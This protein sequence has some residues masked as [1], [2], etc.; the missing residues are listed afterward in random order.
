MLLQY[1]NNNQL[2][3]M[4]IRQNIQQYKISGIIK[5]ESIIENVLKPFKYQIESKNLT[6]TI[7][8]IRWDVTKLYNLD[9][10]YYE[11]LLFNVV[12]N[13]VKFNVKN[14]KIN[15]EIEMITI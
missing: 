2:L 3:K 8:Q 5:P 14:G 13:A 7:S 4:R 9:W 11:L 10:S 6:I 1:Y 12:Q 15:F